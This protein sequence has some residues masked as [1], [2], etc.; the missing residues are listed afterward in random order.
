[1]TLDKT[2][3]GGMTSFAGMEGH[4]L[5]LLALQRTLQY[6]RRTRRRQHSS[7]FCR[8]HLFGARVPPI[9]ENTMERVSQNS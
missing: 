2:L 8:G 5:E 1:M 9:V 4:S 3:I 6:S 7:C